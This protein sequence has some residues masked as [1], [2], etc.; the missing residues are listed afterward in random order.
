MKSTLKVKQKIFLKGL[1]SGGN[2]YPGSNATM[3][4]DS[5]TISIL[6]TQQTPTDEQAWHERIDET[7]R[8]FTEEDLDMVALYFEQVWLCQ[9]VCDILFLFQ[10]QL[11]KHSLQQLISH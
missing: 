5:A 9:N 8:W 4:G 10:I 2:I 1:R 6:E 3:G 7:M 11:F